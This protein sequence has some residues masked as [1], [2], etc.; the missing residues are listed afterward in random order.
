MRTAK[1][2][3]EISTVYVLVGWWKA[4]IPVYNINY[5]QQGWVFLDRERIKLGHPT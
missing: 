1:G 3:D 4:R 2:T 5:S